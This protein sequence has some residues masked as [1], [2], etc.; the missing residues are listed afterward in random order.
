MVKQESWRQCGMGK[1]RTDLSFTLAWIHIPPLSYS[2]S[3]YLGKFLNLSFLIFIVCKLGI[4]VTVSQSFW[5]GQMRMYVVYLGLC[6]TC[7]MLIVTI[8]V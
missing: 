2:S 8:R 7:Y 5:E 6:L 3:V 1:D 4:M